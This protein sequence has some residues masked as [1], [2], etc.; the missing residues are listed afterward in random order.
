LD[1]DKPDDTATEQTSSVATLRRPAQPEPEPAVREKRGGGE[2][3]PLLPSWLTNR[4]D[5]TTTVKGVAHRAAHRSAWH[6]IRIPFV[7]IP[8]LVVIW[9]PIGAVRVGKKLWHIIGDGEA[10]ALCR[11]AATGADKSLWLHLRRERNERRIGRAKIAAI[12]AAPLLITVLVGWFLLPNWEWW[13]AVSLTVLACGYAGRPLDKPAIPPA[14]IPSA[15]PGPLRAPVIIGALTSLGISRMGERDTDQIKLLC[16]VSRDGPGYRADLELPPGVPASAVIDKRSE[17]SAALRR[18]LGCV[19]PEVGKRHEGHLVM[20]VADQNM[21]TTKQ[22][23]WPLRK[24]CSANIFKP[25]PAFTDQRGRWVDLTLAY[26]S[27]VIGAVP[28]I[29][30]T[31]TLRELLL[32][33]GMDA[34]TKVYAFDLKG[35]GDLSPIALFAHAYGVGDEPDEIDEQLAVMR[36]LREELR[37]RAKV[38]RGLTHEECPENKVT[39]QLAS[40]RE[41]GLEPIFVGVDEC[42]IWFDHEDKAIKN[43]FIAIC[44]DLVKRGPALGIMCYFATQKPDAKSIPTAIAD[45]AIVRICLKVSGQVGND[46]VLGTSSYKQGIRATMFSFDD[47]GIAY[48]RSD[49]ADAKIVRSVV[50]LD[51]VASEKLANRIRAARQ[52]AHRLTGHAIGGKMDHEADQVVLLD[53]VRQ[54][55]GLADTMHLVDIATGL[56]A[57]RPPLYGTLDPRSLGAQLRAAGVRVETVYVAG[58]SRDDAPG[59]GVRREWLDV[60]TTALMGDEE[61]SEDDVSNVR[62]LRRVTDDEEPTGTVRGSGS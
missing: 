16:D 61:P 57:L 49:G 59:K 62:P 14:T 45:N 10:S 53:D 24:T 13:L 42:Q 3:R 23:G 36:G 52:Q 11:D 38:I 35:T 47:K 1:T 39:D 21:N 19:W 4:Q 54:V 44:T 50:G 48:L 32:I 55:M 27:G 51:A 12:L 9:A 17:L 34:R 26:T 22:A 15:T 37:R 31:F 5:F 30:K 18:E 33:A 56:A 43:E 29:G 6:G 8:K 40:R 41:L 20:Y 28:R 58:K 60:S 2:L 7:Y 46:Q 25:A